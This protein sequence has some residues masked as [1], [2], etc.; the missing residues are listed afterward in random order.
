MSLL[1]LRQ[2]GQP[3][4]F[5]DGVTD[6]CV[7]ESGLCADVARDRP[8]GGNADAEFGFPEHID[9]L[10]MQLP[11]CSQRRPGGVRVLD[12][13][14]E[15]GQRRVALEF[16]DQPAMP[17]NRFD[18]Y[19]EEVV[20]QAHDFGGRACCC[21]VGRADQVDEQDGDFALLPAELGAPFERAASD[22]FPDVAA[23]QVA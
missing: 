5:V 14:A 16:V 23:E 20:E 2:L 6:H 21:Q 8:A 3:C 1:H 13:C 4:G 19:A 11:G 22:I 7:L 12:R 10:V 17:V 9:E 18:D 15:N